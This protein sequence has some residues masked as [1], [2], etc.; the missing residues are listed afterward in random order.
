MRIFAVI[1]VSAVVGITLGSSLALIQFRTDRDLPIIPLEELSAQ[2]VPSSEPA[3]RIRVIDP[4]LKFGTM[5]RG[6]TKTHDFVVQNVGT[7]PLTLELG[8]T[9][10]KCTVGVADKEPISPGDSVLVHLEWTANSA[11]GPFRQTANLHTND[12][13]Q[14]RVVLSVEGQVSAAEGV[15]PPEFLFDKVTAGESKS[16]QVFVMSMFED[17]IKVDHPELVHP[18]T[19]PFFDVKIEPVSR[20]ELPNPDAKSGVLITLRLKPGL[21]LG[22]F[23]QRLSLHTSLRD[24]EKLDIPIYGRVIGDITVHGTRWDD[25]RGV[26]RLGNVKSSEGKRDK[27]NLVVRG[28]DAA[29]IQLKVVDTDPP[30]LSARLGE[31]TR[32]NDNLVHVPLEIEVPAGTPPM[33]RLGTDQGK[34]G[35]IVVGT[36]H[37]AIRELIINVQFAI[38]R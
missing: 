4:E 1:L 22:V 6:T 15:E 9:S 32:L 31:P 36:S 5:Q 33:V 12:P 29:G 19:R 23:S 13:L 24:A 28:P 14:S 35:R 10:C 26:L 11:P 16:V 2:P 18:E 38:E 30:Q 7:A 17:Q 37:A 20:E 8:E 25:E 27:L 3:P 21:P 34:P